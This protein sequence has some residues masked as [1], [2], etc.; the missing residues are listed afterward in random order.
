MLHIL[1]KVDYDSL[2]NKELASWMD[3]Q[4][5]TKIVAQL[6]EQEKDKIDW[7]VEIN[8]LSQMQNWGIKFNKNVPRSLGK[9]L[10][11]ICEN[12]T[13]YFN[14]NF[15]SRISLNYTWPLFFQKFP[16]GQIWL[17]KISKQWWD[18][19]WQGEKFIAETTGYNKKRFRGFCPQEFSGLQVENFPF[20]ALNI[21]ICGIYPLILCDYIHTTSDIVF[22]YIPDRAFKYSQLIEGRTLYQE[23]LWKLHHVFD[24]QWTF[25]SSRGP[26]SAV[27]ALDLN[28]VKQLGYFNWIIERISSRMCDIVAMPDPFLREQLGMTIN[29]AICDAQLCTTCELPYMSKYFFFGCL[30]KLANLAVL[31]NMETNEIDAWERLLNEEFL[32][33]EVLFKI[34]DIPDNAGEYLR[35]IVKHVL[36]EIKLSDLSPQDLR[37]IRNSHHGYKLRSNAFERLMEKTGEINND[38][39]LIL[40]PLILFFLS[41]KWII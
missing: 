32:N 23:L 36:E 18:E 19:I 2:S 15:I 21:L 13:T 1:R 11:Y 28:P 38:I 31:L 27:K 24:D 40:T 6:Q 7:R 22:I 16:L 26:K 37:D 12:S 29:R 41:K 3:D 17:P 9:S 4:F 35:W 8:E 34:K 20:I 14:Q 39:T 5:Q 33:K 25:D 10:F 30:D